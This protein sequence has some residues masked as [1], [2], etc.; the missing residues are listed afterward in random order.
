[1]KILFAS[2]EMVPFAKTGGLADVSGAL[3]K[4]IEKLGEDVTVIMPKYQA[5]DEKKNTLEDTGKKISVPISNR[6]K[7]AKIYKGYINS[8]QSAVGSRQSKIPI[9]FIDKKEYYDRPYLYGTPQGDYPDNAERFIFFSRAI[10]ETC[11]TIGL[12]PDVIHCND[13]QTGMVP[14]YLKTI[15]KDDPYL[16]DTATLFTV[17]NLGYQGLFWHLD[18]HLTNLGWDIFNPEGIEFYGKMNILKGGLVY[19]DIITT[20]SRTYSHEIQTKEYGCGLD[21][22]L[23]KRKDDLYG[24]LNG[25]D[26]EEWNPATDKYIAAKYLKENLSGKWECKKDLLKIYG[27]KPSKEIPVLSVISRL[28]DQKGF[29][30][31]AEIV[32]EL[33]ELD[34]QFVLL[35]TGEEKYHKLFE[36]IGKKYPSKA[37]IKIGFDNALAHKI[38]AGADMFLMPSRYEPCGL[39][40]LYSLKYGTIPIVRATGG[41]NDTV[42]N[43][44]PVTKNGNGFKFAEYSSTALFSAI[45]TAIDF[46]KNKTQWNRIMMNAMGEDFSWSHSA[47]EYVELYRKVINKRTK[48]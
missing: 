23:R 32:N 5:V 34:I 8:Q 27:L 45:K 26:Y 14:V 44:N 22:V 6:I 42:E 1:M 46:H 9:Y 47:R 36:E 31:V 12:K 18:M 38:E 17:H 29:N 20:V 28:A 43:Y 30:L 33:M 2:P 7:E 19:S 41:L 40:Q 21:G 48:T 16:K 37:G 10:L 39:N 4:A 25:I 35:G 3:P 24:V 13:W 15:Y 11:K